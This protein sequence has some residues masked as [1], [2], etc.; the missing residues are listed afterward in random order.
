MKLHHKSRQSGFTLIELLA[1]VAILGILA[2]IAIPRIFGAMEGAR[3]GVDQANIMLIQSAVAQWAVLNNPEGILDTVGPRLGW[4]A[5][6]DGRPVAGSDFILTIPGGTPPVTS[7][8][9]PTFLSAIPAVPAGLTGS[10]MLRFTLVDGSGA[11]AR[12]TATVVR[13]APTTP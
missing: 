12:H 13:V 10:Y 3:L 4:D 8:L 6:V 1:V 9:V 5:I 7:P 2:G 11:T